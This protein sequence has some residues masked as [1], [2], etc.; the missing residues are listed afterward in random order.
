[1]VRGLFTMRSSSLDSPGKAYWEQCVS[2]LEHIP[3]PKEQ[4]TEKEW[5]ER[6]THGYEP[7]Q[8]HQETTE[9]T[10]ISDPFTNPHPPMS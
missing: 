4:E 2:L 6:G 10:S 9:P 7:E 1:M 3:S 5:R 8:T